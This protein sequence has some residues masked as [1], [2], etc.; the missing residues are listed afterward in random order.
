MLKLGDLIEWCNKYSQLPSDVNEAFVISQETSLPN[1]PNLSFRFVL[2]TRLLLEKCLERKTIAIDATYKLNWLD[3][4]LM[5]YGTVDREK[6]FHPLAY[7]CCSHEKTYDFQFI[8]QSI[9]NAI[10]THLDADFE[11]TIMIADGADAIRNAF[12]GSFDSAEFDIMCFAHVLRNCTKRPFTSK[13]NKQL[14]LDDIRQMQLAPNRATFNMM[15]KL[16]CEKW[17]RIESDFVAYFEKEWLGPHCN[18]FEGAANYTPSTNNA[19]KSHIAVIKRLITLRRRLPM[20]QFLICMKDMTESISKQFSNGDR[21]IA[22]EPKIAKK[23]FEEVAIMGDSFK[24]FKAKKSISADVTIFSIPSR[25][26][27]EDNANESYYKTLTKTTW[28]S[29]DEFIV[30]GFQQFHIVQFSSD[31]WKT[32]ST[33]TCPAFFKQN[34]CKHIVAIGVRLGAV[35]MPATVNL[36]PLARTKR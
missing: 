12:Y 28:K 8:F 31:C 2:S 16:F 19:L 18:W 9:K 4:P 13:T 36:V 7:A 22:S 32:K 29:F 14:V 24:A 1:D 26:C 25:E 35:I 27:A 17:K 11:P 15:A 23:T 34:I 3:Y 30:H 10:K 33:C 20:N 5:V 21:K 6:K